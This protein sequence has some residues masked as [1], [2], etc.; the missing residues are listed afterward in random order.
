M[1]IFKITLLGDGTVISWVH[2]WTCT[3]GLE[4]PISQRW[5]VI[6][7]VSLTLF[8][9]GGLLAV[10]YKNILCTLGYSTPIPMSIFLLLQCQRLY[11]SCVLTWNEIKSR[12]RWPGSGSPLFTPTT[13]QTPIYNCTHL[14]KKKKERKLIPIRLCFGTDLH[15]VQK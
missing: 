12:L 5:T 1:Y 10:A 7:L 11:A 15:W 8:A 6:A 4:V 13:V 3:I 14:W 9:S 2:K